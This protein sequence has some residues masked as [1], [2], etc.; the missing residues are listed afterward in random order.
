MTLIKA[1]TSADVTKILVLPIVSCGGAA[2][3]LLIQ[4]EIR[5]G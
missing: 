4:P 1:V 3:G 5:N 2:H